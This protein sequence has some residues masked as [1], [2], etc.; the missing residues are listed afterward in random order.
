MV[1]APAAVTALEARLLALEQKTVA[2]AAAEAK[3]AADVDPDDALDYVPYYE[4]R[5]LNPHQVRPQGIPDKP[6]LWPLNEGSE[7]YKY[8]FGKKNAAYHEIG[9]LACLLGAGY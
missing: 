2:K 8:L 4:G 9:T 3:A 5:G 6:Q 1:A 7:V